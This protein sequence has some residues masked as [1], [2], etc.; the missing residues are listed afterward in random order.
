[1]CGV[2]YPLKMPPEI[3]SEEQHNNEVSVSCHIFPNF[4]S[5]EG[6]KGYFKNCQWPGTLKIIYSN[7]MI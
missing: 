6:R 4:L 1:M 5:L 3:D 2:L 7:V